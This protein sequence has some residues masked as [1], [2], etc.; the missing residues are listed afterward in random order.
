ML[1]KKIQVIIVLIAS[2]IVCIISIIR[3]Y[4]LLFTLKALLL[5][6]LIFY[7]VGYF[8][9]IAIKRINKKNF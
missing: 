1:E 9:T 8:V 7:I 5:S 6:I 2:L 4:D 3:K